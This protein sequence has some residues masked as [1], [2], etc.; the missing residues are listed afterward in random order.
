MKKRALISVS[1]KSGIEDFAKGLI[2]KGYEIISTGGTYDLLKQYGAINIPD[3]T[4]FPEAFDG[5][6]KTLHPA[7]HGGILAVR[8]NTA[9]ME[10]LKNLEYN[11]IDIVAV[12][13]YP[14]KATIQ[15]PSTTYGEAI[16]NIDIGGPAMI[17]S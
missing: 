14:F 10:T 7:I 2:A 11:T 9:H 5:R 16:E 3:I 6:V 12:N 15:K 17:R 4:G 1:D 8:D 13:L